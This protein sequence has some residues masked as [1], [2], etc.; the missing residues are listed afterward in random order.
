MSF[1][2]TSSEDTLTVNEKEATRLSAR[3]MALAMWSLSELMPE[4][5]KVR[6]ELKSGTR[7]SDEFFKELTR[8]FQTSTKRRVSVYSTTYGQRGHSQAVVL[9]GN[10]ELTVKDALEETPWLTAGLF[11]SDPGRTLPGCSTDSCSEEV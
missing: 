9:C 7:L 5:W 11:P 3:S 10:S 6:I 4:R 8:L 2:K 1:R